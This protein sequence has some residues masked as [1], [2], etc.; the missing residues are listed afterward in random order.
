MSLFSL[1]MSDAPEKV[2][3]MTSLF[4]CKMFLNLSCR[5]GNMRPLSIKAK[6]FV[7]YF[8]GS[9]ISCNCLRPLR[10]FLSSL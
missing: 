10:W 4:S 3:L 5:P 8:I 1:R 7:G 2:Q 9:D 6:V